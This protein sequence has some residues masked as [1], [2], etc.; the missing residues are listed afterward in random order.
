MVRLWTRCCRVDRSPDEQAER[1]A[2]CV[3]SGE[4]EAIV[5]EVVMV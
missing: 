5:W 2:D 3:S 4:V 1:M